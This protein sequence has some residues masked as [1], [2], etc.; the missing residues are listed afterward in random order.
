MTQP[1]RWGIL[2]AGRIAAHFVENIKGYPQAAVVAVASLNA[3]DAAEFSALHGIARAHSN[4][5]ELLAD[6]GVDAVYIATPHHVHA[7]WA[8]RASDAGKHIL[9]EKPLGV[10]H[11]EAM[12][13]VE[14]ARSNRVFL[15][16]GFAY[17]CFP[18]IAAIVERIQAGAIGEVRLIEAK[19]TM[20][21]PVDATDRLFMHD[22]AGGSILD[23][24][25][26]AMSLVRLLAGATE[27]TP[28]ADPERVAGTAL[29]D[30]ETRVDLSAGASMHF[31]SGVEAMV[32]GGFRFRDSNLLVVHGSDGRIE[33]E[34]PWA[35]RLTGF[36]VITKSGAEP[37]EVENIPSRFAT[38]VEAVHEALAAG[39]LQSPAIPWADTLGNMAALDKWR[40]SV[41]MIYDFEKDASHRPPLR[42]GKPR[43][44]A[45]HRM[46][47]GTVPG[48]DSP[49]SRLVMGVD[50]QGTQRHA[51]VMFDD[52]LER[53]GNCFDTAHIY[54]GGAL[55]KR[56]GNWIADRGVR[57]DVFVIVKGAHTPFCHPERLAE[58]LAIS[59][60]RL[61]IDRA[62]F[63]IMHRDNPDIPAG[64]FIEVLNAQ[65]DAGRVG[66]FGGSNWSIE[67]VTEANEYAARR[68]LRGMTVLSNN[69]S[70]ARMV[71]PVWAGCVSAS[72]PASRAWLKRTQ[73]PLFAWSSQARGFFTDRADPG[74]V[75][76]ESLQQCWCSEDN[77]R[78]RERAYSLA[79]QRGVHPINIALAYVLAQPFPTFPLIGPRVLE[80][81]VSSLPGLDVELT[82]QELAWLNLEADT[83]A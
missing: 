69:F 82:P 8:V 13:A 80:E 71:Q 40:S 79:A 2:G 16:E 48:I 9:C 57:E 44:R 15:M 53:G 14:A 31:A 65:V 74:H 62:D 49:V 43:P 75:T 78:R 30:A 77:Y 70:L 45:G 36:R 67:R 1:I 18:R 76:D 35:G 7:Q 25:C 47:Y 21:A 22:A 56:L 4:C 55:E 73:M 19:L 60:E 10:N 39:L 5:E 23:V 3:E 50:N 51:D 38:E 41:G 37:I 34:D 72:D 52:F 58:Q 83:P 6:P 81:T 28:F 42:P 26:Y 59:L 32:Y 17:R 24:G 46:K 66:V 33:M 29:I 68:G 63:Y 54:G 11:A 64:E 27:G 12:A 61:R 20:N